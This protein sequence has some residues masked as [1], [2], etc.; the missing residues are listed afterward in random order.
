MLRVAE[1]TLRHVPDVQFLHYGPVTPGEEDYGRSCE[2]LHAQLGLGERFRFMGRTTDPTGVV[3]DAD[4]VLMSS[5]SE[6]LPMSIL[7]AMGQGRPVVSTGVGG[8]RDV[9]SG[10]GVV[11]AP[12]DVHG[13]AMGITTL[14]R[15]PQLAWSLGQRGHRR[16]SRLFNE[17]SC[18]DRYRDIL[19]AAVSVPLTGADPTRRRLAS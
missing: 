15:N 7:E 1:E 9:V 19:N 17:A 12:G 13:L 4:V 18:V 11:T 14:L 6:G 10:C 16:L 8:V 3:R 2:T 5:I